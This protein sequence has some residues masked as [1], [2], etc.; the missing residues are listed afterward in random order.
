MTSTFDN[1]IASYLRAEADRVIVRDELDDIDAGITVV[2]V[3]G[4]TDTRRTPLLV[5]AA[6]VIALV[7]GIAVV[8]GNA[9]SPV[10]VGT[11]SGTPGPEAAPG[12]PTA[13][14][15]PSTQTN[16]TTVPPTTQAMVELPGGARF[17]G[18]SP[19]CTTADDVVYEC[20]I[21]AFPDDVESVDM[22]GYTNILVDASSQVSGGCRSIS[23]DATELLCYLGQHAVDA[24]VVGADYLGDWAPQ[25]YTAG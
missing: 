4:N 21:P 9:G 1:D 20:T 25:G 19:S 14:T 16:P 5:A 23:I 2:P 22:H 13:P 18:L 6:V 11:G 15:E 10:G 12:E 17:Q 7:G 3:A 8:R 24:G